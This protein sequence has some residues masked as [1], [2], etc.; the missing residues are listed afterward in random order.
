MPSKSLLGNPFRPL[1]IEGAVL[2]TDFRP[3]KVPV[4]DE[5]S[6]PQTSLEDIITLPG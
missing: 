6:T 4:L 1:E 3:C 2:W 5:T